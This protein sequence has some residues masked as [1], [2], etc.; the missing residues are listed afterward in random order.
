MNRSRYPTLKRL[1]CFEHKCFFKITI[2][3]IFLAPISFKWCV[4]STSEKAK[5][6]DFVKYVNE[7]AQNASMEVTTLCVVGT[8]ADD[9]V[10]KIKN[11]EADLITLDAGR[12]LDAGRTPLALQFAHFLLPFLHPTVY[13][14]TVLFTIEHSENP[15]FPALSSVG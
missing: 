11:N 3:L 7:T 10:D 5:C 2:F 6:D 14:N 1:S 8:S 4:K 9:C 15:S 12:V 13:W